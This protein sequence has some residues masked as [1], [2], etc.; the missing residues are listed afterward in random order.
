MKTEEISIEEVTKTEEKSVVKSKSPVIILTIALAFISLLALGMLFCRFNNQSQESTKEEDCICKKCE[1]TN[2]CDCSL[3]KTELTNSGW[4]LYS[5]P[6]IRFSVEIPSDFIKF[7][8]DNSDHDLKSRWTITQYIDSENKSKDFGEYVKTI[9]MEFSPFYIKVPSLDIPTHGESF[10]YVT[11]LKNTKEKTLE[12]LWTLEKAPY[13]DPADEYKVEGKL[14]EKWGV[15]A[16]EFK[17]S[18]APYGPY[19]GYLVVSNG[20]VYRISYNF[21]TLKEVAEATSS[22]IKIIDSIQFN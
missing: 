20:F 11:V 16:Y 8:L 15:P 14:I 9:N 12:E 17:I 19:T 4:A 1:E 22:G 21:S 5:L 6:D 18:G 10:I 13:E 2:D 3:K 7:N